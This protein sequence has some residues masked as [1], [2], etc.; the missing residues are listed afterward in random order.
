MTGL[1]REDAGCMIAALLAVLG[2]ILVVL[3]VL[4]LLS[5]IH[6]AV[7]WWVLLLVGAGLILLGWY[8]RNRTPVV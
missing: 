1:A 3:G 8:L 6:I 2:A 7:A 5:V 4:V